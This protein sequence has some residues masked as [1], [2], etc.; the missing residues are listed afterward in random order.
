MT[1]NSTVE[2]ELMECACHQD[3]T[4]GGRS[5]MNSSDCM[6][7]CED[8]QLHDRPC[9]E[10]RLLLEC[11]VDE[12]DDVPAM[13]DDLGNVSCRDHAVEYSHENRAEDWPEWE[14]LDE[15]DTFTDVLNAAVKTWR[16]DHE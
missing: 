11:I 10:H 1:R 15:G 13:F 4:D 8:C 3:A 16:S 12:C 2:I 7:H 6:I 9:A 5:F 14:P